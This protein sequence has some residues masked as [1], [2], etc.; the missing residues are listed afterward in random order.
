M[1]YPGANAVS[2]LKLFDLSC[3][4]AG[5]NERTAAQLNIPYETVV[6]PAAASHAT[7]YPGAENMV[8]KVLFAPDTG[9]LLGAQAVGGA[10]VDKRMD[11]LATAMAAGMTSAGPGPAGPELRSALLLRQGPGERGRPGDG[12]HP[13]RLGEAVA[14]GGPAQRIRGPQGGAAGRAHRR[15]LPRAASRAR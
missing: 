14:R 6:L 15:N 8:L 10:G 11:V 7:Y 9:K 3:A 13:A 1:A 4:V 12:K 5:L 2:I